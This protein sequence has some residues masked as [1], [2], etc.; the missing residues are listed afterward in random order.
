MGRWSC[1]RGR[2]EVIFGRRRRRGRWGRVEVGLLGV[3]DLL[4]EG[5]E[6]K[7]GRWSRGRSGTMRPL[8]GFS[9]LKVKSFSSLNRGKVIHWRTHC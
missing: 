9:F 6:G 3:C 2:G 8:H 7:E 4:R 1:F 5:S